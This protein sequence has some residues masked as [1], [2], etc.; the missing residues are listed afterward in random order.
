MR[1]LRCFRESQPLMYR[2]EAWDSKRAIWGKN[3]TCFSGVIVSY[4]CCCLVC[5]SCTLNSPSISRDAFKGGWQQNGL[6]G[7]LLTEYIS[8]L[9]ACNCGLRHLQGLWLLLRLWIHHALPALL[10]SLL[11]RRGG[12]RE[13]ER[14]EGKGKSSWSPALSEVSHLANIWIANA[15]KV[16]WWRT[17]TS[18]YLH[19][20]Q[21]L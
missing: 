9:R 21:P 1:M 10:F 18:S 20:C 2:L 13:G 17:G 7:G 15:G 5:L 12:R 14:R 16:I 4:A 6:N 3:L 8:N 11:F 19:T